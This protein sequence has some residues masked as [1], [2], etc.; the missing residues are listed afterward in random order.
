M[1]FIQDKQPFNFYDNGYKAGRCF[2][3]VEGYTIDT[4]EAKKQLNKA[5]RYIAK[6][7]EGL[8]GIEKGLIEVA[9]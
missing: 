6:L 8:M 5:K 1:K 3:W 7:E 2:I 9:K 4:V